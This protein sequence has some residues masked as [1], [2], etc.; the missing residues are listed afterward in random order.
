MHA[1]LLV[2]RPG[3]GRM[4]GGQ[5]FLLQHPERGAQSISGRFIRREEG[6]VDSENVVDVINGR[7]QEA[8]L[9]QCAG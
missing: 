2:R 6:T 7:P 9:A 5:L 8:R 3:S 1:G 4:P